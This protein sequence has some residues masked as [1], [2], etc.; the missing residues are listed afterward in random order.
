MAKILI[1][2]D[3][4]LACESL[5]D[6]LKTC[7]FVADVAHSAILAE[8]FL[9]TAR[10]DCL[11]VDWQMPAKT[12]IELIAEL[13]SK[14]KNLPII[15][16]TGKSMIDDKVLGLN[17]GADDYLTKPYSLKELVSRVRAIL[18]RPQALESDEFVSGDL[19]VRTASRQVFCAGLE[20]SLTRQEYLLLEFLIRNKNQ[21]FSSEQLVQNAWSTLSESSPDTVRV[22]LAN[23]RKKLKVGDRECPI[24]T[25]HGQGYTLKDP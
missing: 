25:I 20:I 16:L 5:A 14:G 22:H 6:G 3:D 18:R 15:M 11:I 2:D 1:I 4:E 9:A 19:I 24:K 23:L 10:Y 13:R 17:T 8:E 12:G 21:V 7:G